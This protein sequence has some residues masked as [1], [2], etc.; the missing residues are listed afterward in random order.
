MTESGQR[1][2]IAIKFDQRAVL[3]HLEVRP[4][5]ISV[6]NDLLRIPPLFLLKDLE[7][8]VQLVDFLALPLYFTLVLPFRPKRW[9]IG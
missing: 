1:L 5:V 2:G 9:R 6:Q 4:T 3:E 8:I 7:K